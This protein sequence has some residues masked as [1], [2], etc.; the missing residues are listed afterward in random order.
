MAAKLGTAIWRAM[1][2][3]TS[4]LIL[5]FFCFIRPFQALLLA[6][7]YDS[8]RAIQMNTFMFCSSNGNPWTPRQAIAFILKCLSKRKIPF[9]FQQYRHFQTANVKHFSSNDSKTVLL[10]SDDRG[11]EDF[12]LTNVESDGNDGTGSVVETMHRQAGHTPETGDER[13]SQSAGTHSGITLDR[14][15]QFCNASDAWQFLLGI[16]ADW[17][18]SKV[19]FHHVCGEGEKA[20]KYRCNA[21]Q[22][23]DSSQGIAI[24]GKSSRGSLKRSRPDRL[25]GAK[26]IPE[27]TIPNEERRTMELAKN[28][29]KSLEHTT[30]AGVPVKVSTAPSTLQCHVDAS[31]SNGKSKEIN[32][33]CDPLS[34]HSAAL[35]L[36][37]EVFKSPIGQFTCQLQAQAI[38]EVHRGDKDL[39]VVMGTGEGNSLVYQLPA[40]MGRGGVFYNIVVVPLVS[41][42]DDLMQ[43][44]SKMGIRVAG[45]EHRNDAGIDLLFVTPAR[46][47][48]T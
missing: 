47:S 46:V 8:E 40:L 44:S 29:H 41:L 39:I 18:Y 27:V 1:D 13:Y 28:S 9:N 36:L 35:Q 17:G 32:R 43:S 19:S 31:A 26:T 11:A 37:R 33:T 34:M 30:H 24:T 25:V 38:Q 2:S 12:V 4:R 45:W 5:L 3:E 6:G 14:R 15:T 42:I 16:N 21:L 22:K 20:S 10:L 23:N 7:K 48:G